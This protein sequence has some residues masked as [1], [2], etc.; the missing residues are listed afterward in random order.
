M[1]SKIVVSVVF[2]QNM[3]EASEV[4][5]SVNHPESCILF[6]VFFA[7]IFLALAHG[8]LIPAFTKYNC[9]ELTP[10]LRAEVQKMM[11]F[12]DKGIFCDDGSVLYTIALRSWRAHHL[13]E[14][15]TNFNGWKTVAFNGFSSLDEFFKPE[16]TEATRPERAVSK[17]QP[18]TSAAYNNYV[19]PVPGN[20]QHLC[21]MAIAKCRRLIV[22][23]GKDAS[24]DLTYIIQV[25]QKLRSITP[26][27]EVTVGNPTYSKVY[28]APSTGKDEV[29]S[30]YWSEIVRIA[31]RFRPNNPAILNTNPN[32]DKQ[33]REEGHQLLA[34]SDG[35][36]SQ[37]S[38]SSLTEDNKH[39][40]SSTIIKRDSPEKSRELNQDETEDLSS[41]DSDHVQM[42][43]VKQQEM[44]S[45]DLPDEQQRGVKQEQLDMEQTAE[46]D[47]GMLSSGTGPGTSKASTPSRAKNLPRKENPVQSTSKILQSKESKFEIL[48]NSKNQLN[49][50]RKD[51]A[52]QNQNGATRNNMVRSK[53][54]DGFH[55]NFEPDYGKPTGLYHTDCRW[56]ADTKLFKANM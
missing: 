43:T 13:R 32:T 15:W 36:T 45:L 14:R 53:T 21:D 47:E 38:S 50:S 3:V 24:E 2:L 48:K 12:F 46:I 26:L 17:Q 11:S 22:S 44:T 19:L 25:L 52:N 27:M 28:K 37:A 42:L 1:L 39:A 18:S 10:E 16:V 5:S 20:A 9:Q 55:R 7:F 6:A 23:T 29:F 51:R 4:H 35:V 33:T 40:E 56:Q 54:F 30:R 8:E 41:V 31:D 34:I 49:T